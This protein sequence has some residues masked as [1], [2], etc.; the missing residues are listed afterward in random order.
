MEDEKSSYTSIA[1]YREGL[2]H[3]DYFKELCVHENHRKWI[4]IFG[5]LE[6]V[7]ET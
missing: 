1:C 5:S 3:W 6:I 4:Q 2:F 7:P